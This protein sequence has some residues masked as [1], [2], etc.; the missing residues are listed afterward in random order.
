MALDDAKRAIALRPA[1]G[2]AYSRAGLAAL[3]GGD[4]AR[5]ILD[6]EIEIAR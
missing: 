1:W 2:K 4:E 3:S 6:S 5:A